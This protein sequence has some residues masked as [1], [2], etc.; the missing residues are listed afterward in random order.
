MEYFYTFLKGF[1]MGAA[2]IIPGVSGGTIAF[3]TGIYERLIN[4]LKSFDLK[5]IRY[6]LKFDFGS[7]AKHVDFGFILA[8]GLGVVTSVLTLAK[9]LKGAY[10]DHPIMVN[11]FFFGLI[12]ASIF[13][14]GRMVRSWR[15]MQIVALLLGLGVA[16]S[17][18]LMSPRGV[19]PDPSYLALCGVAA[20][21]FVAGSLIIIWP[22]KNAVYSGVI[23]GKVITWDRYFPN[24]LESS[25]WIAIAWLLAGIALIAV[26]EK[27]SA[28]PAA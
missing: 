1:A 27:L 9:L 7:F 6:L 4:T 2:N 17:L 18:A 5:A 3:I 16:V 24:I 12:L 20:T 23:K 13:S 8:L 10:L 25:T 11:A 14:V 28:K 19:N 26:I 22:W 15:F 21:G